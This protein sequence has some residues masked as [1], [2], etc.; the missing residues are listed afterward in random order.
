VDG[1]S[2]FLVGDAAGGPP[3]EADY[4]DL[5]ARLVEIEAD[6]EAV[7]DLLV[8]RTDLSQARLR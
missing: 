2:F 5:I 7:D 6:V 8:L 4:R 1:R 3:A